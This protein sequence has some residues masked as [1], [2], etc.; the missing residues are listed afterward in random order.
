MT[1]LVCDDHP[2]VR[3]AIAATVAEVA[4]QRPVLTAKDFG[5]AWRLAG[6][7]PA[8]VL[9]IVDLQMPGAGP[10]E[11]LRGIR[12]RAPD[13]KIVVITGSESDADLLA[14]LDLGVDGFIPKTAEPGV[15]EAAIR[16]VLAGGRYLPPRVAEIVSGLRARA[17]T[18]APPV[19]APYGRIS[20]RQREV[21]RFLARGRSNKEIA[22]V[23][24]LSPATVKSHVA[25]IL[26]V[27][28][29]A[30]RTE[31]A[32]SARAKGMY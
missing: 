15:V 24:A 4:P 12:D 31:A 27:L 5:E 2:L 32:L 17:A 19:E 11:G 14:A 7:E 13:A 26:A 29:A 21:L 8:L 20:E 9:C 18:P 23:M 22:E 25:H 3:A 30:N 6:S 1:I 28:G 16:L 10:G